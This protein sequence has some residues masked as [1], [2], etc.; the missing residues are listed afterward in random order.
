MLDPSYPAPQLTAPCL[1]ACKQGCHWEAVCK[2]LVFSANGVTA[3]S[4]YYNISNNV[5][6]IEHHLPLRSECLYTLIWLLYWNSPV[7]NPLPLTA[8]ENCERLFHLY[9]TFW[10]VLYPNFNIV[11]MLLYGF[12]LSHFI[13]HIWTWCCKLAWLYLISYKKKFAQKKPC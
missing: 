12:V 7:S 1:V 2:E 9:Y 6:I 10:A 5:L 8:D 4:Y 13:T 3:Y 11:I